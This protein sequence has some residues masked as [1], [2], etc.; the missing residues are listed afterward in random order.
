MVAMVEAV[1]EALCGQASSLTG[2]APALTAATRILAG[3]KLAIDARYCTPP[4]V[5]VEVQL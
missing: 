2:Y 5:I 3:E 1:Q 4:F